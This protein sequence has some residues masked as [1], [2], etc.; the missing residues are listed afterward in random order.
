MTAAQAREA[1][2]R[3]LEHAGAIEAGDPHAD[4]LESLRAWIDCHRN[5]QCPECDPL[6]GRAHES[7]PLTL[8]EQATEAAIR[9]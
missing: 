1:A 8:A 9:R 6:T 7:Y 4:K 3:L 5:G 2:L